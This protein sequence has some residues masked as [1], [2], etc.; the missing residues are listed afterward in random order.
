MA[1][2]TTVTTLASTNLDFTYSASIPLSSSAKFSINES[3]PSGTTNNY[4][5]FSF[6]TGSGRFLAMASDLTDYNLR[7][8][9]NTSGASAT[10][11]T[12]LTSTTGNLLF[13]TFG[14]GGQKD[15]TGAAILNITG[16]LYVD[17]TGTSLA[18]F[19]LDSLF[20]VT[21]GIA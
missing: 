18:S 20:D 2:D 9:S 7:I 8:K 17:N 5:N 11:N 21:P 19:R 3:I 12:F 1:F 4:V 6:N 10:Q 13:Y 15:S 14:A 16:G